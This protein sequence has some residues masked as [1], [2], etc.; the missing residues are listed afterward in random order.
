MQP[1]GP[2]NG[3]PPEGD[4]G[5]S[6][7]TGFCSTPRKPRPLRSHSLCLSIFAVIYTL[8]FC[9][10][11]PPYV[12]EAYTFLLATDSSLTHM[13][14]ALMN[15]ADGTL[16]VFGILV[17]AWGR[18]FGTS[19][20]SLRLAGG[21]FAVLLTWQLSNRLL[22]RFEP[23]PALL[24][25]LLILANRRFIYY[26]IQARFYGLLLFAF[27]LA[28][29]STWD[30]IE[31][32]TASPKRRILHGLSCGLL[33]LSHPLGMVYASIL[34]L[35]YG[36]F[37][38]AQRTFSWASAA[39]FL[40]GPLCFLLWLPAF[41][42]QRKINVVFPPDVQLP[43]W[44]KYWEY[45]FLDSPIFFGVALLGIALFVGTR[46]RRPGLSATEATCPP[47][48][49]S[50]RR[51]VLYSLAF[52]VLLNGVVALLDGAGVIH[53]YFMLAVRYVLVAA[54]AYGVVFA[55]ILETLDQV[56]RQRV[57]PRWAAAISG[58]Q[59]AL[60]AILLLAVMAS[61]WSGWRASRALNETYLK[62]VAQEAQA[63]QL[64]VVCQ[65]HIDAFFLT[66]R[67]AASDV[68]YVLLD[69]FPFRTLML[70]LHKFYPRPAPISP[71]ELQQYSKSFLFVWSDHTAE[72]VESRR[73]G[74]P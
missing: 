7:P 38:V 33:W 73:P 13:L 3:R 71:T 59:H 61:L 40:G 72:I 58:G 43:G 1:D 45:A 10:A 15:G 42:V 5:V 14:S 41:L 62:R 49:H 54:V 16:P 28:F 30:L 47:H 4:R 46:Q 36:G 34:A 11:L 65:N 9:F 64:A 12:D 56:V 25:V 2:T 35:L 8:C 23:V 37:S 29:W 68:K 24:A 74:A 67:T 66:T 70:Q 44:H 18:L 57:R 55:V 52:V 69:R 53:I 17:F 51:L 63:K 48:P 20:L 31:G 6:T 26:V 32:P 27:S 39:A 22:R 60:T 50:N 19:E 21:V